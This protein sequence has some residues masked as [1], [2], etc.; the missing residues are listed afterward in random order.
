VVK[1]HGYTVFT[2]VADPDLG[3]GASMIPGSGSRIQDGKNP[4]PGSGMNVP[5]P[6]IFEN[7]VS[8]FWVDIN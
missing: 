6:G 8:I 4:D 3:S 7:L 5:D 1:V 2:S